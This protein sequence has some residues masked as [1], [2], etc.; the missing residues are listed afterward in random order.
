[1]STRAQIIE[2]AKYVIAKV[3]SDFTWNSVYMADPITLGMWQFYGVEAAQHLY[4]MK[5]DTPEDY[6]KLTDK[7]RG[8]V[9]AHA[10]NSEWWNSYM[11]EQAEANSWKAVA[12]T[13]QANHVLQE[14]Q[15]TTKLDGDITTLKGWGLDIT[16]GPVTAFM[17]CVYHQRPLSCKNILR[18]AGGTATLETMRTT[19]LNDRVLSRYKNRYNTAY[20]M[21]SKW[22]GTSAPPDYGQTGD[23]ETGLNTE[24]I[25]TQPVD[26]K[27]IIQMGDSLVLY[28]AAGSGYEDGVVFYASS[29]QRWI[30]STHPK[31]TEVSSN[32][33]DAGS[34]KDGQAIVDF[35]KSEKNKYSYGQGAGRNNPETSG[36]EDCSSAVARAYRKV[37]GINVGGWT[38]EQRTKGRKIDSGVGK[39][40]DP[41]KAQPADLIIICWS[42]TDWNPNKQHVEMYVGNGE[43]WGHGSGKGPHPNGKV[44]DYLS[45]SCAWELRRY[46]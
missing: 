9:D 5:S 31:R 4:A 21:C 11:I 39:T 12:K 1:M 26:M 44:N 30:P 13:S 29:A 33:T 22:D 17:L 16:N 2:Y 20:D 40:F 42:G 35:F 6:A 34:T 32:W 43:C 24:T 23:V 36:Y 18:A 19:T 8:Y 37:A 27:Y 15:I 7:L 28:G 41:S 14:K 38:G 46:L 10:V 25:E 45:S 3:E